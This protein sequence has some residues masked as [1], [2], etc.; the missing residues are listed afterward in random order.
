[1]SNISSPQ[2]PSMS[3]KH[4]LMNLSR[5]NNNQ[6]MLTNYFQFPP[7]IN[8]IT[9]FNPLTLPTKHQ[10]LSGNLSATVEATKIMHGGM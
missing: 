9:A 10:E 5:L 8:S 1:M 4:P 3:Q 2:M 7:P 6:N